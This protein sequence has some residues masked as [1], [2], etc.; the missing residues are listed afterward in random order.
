MYMLLTN[1]ASSVSRKVPT[2]ISLIDTPDIISI[3]SSQYFQIHFCIYSQILL[4]DF[5]DLYTLI[6]IKLYH[7]V[8]AHMTYDIV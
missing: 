8:T 1:M 3:V 6:M 2:V 7:I 4:H 5:S